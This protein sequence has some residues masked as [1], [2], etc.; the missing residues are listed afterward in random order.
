MAM[1]KREFSSVALYTGIFLKKSWLTDLTN[2]WTKNNEGNVDKHLK[3]GF[4]TSANF[5][6]HTT[7]SA[8]QSL[9]KN[10]N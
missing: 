5:A 2:V 8:L 7:Q 6:E 9:L 3:L 4:P 1:Q 10:K